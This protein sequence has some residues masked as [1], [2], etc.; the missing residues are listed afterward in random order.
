MISTNAMID[1][2][3]VVRVPAPSPLRDLTIPEMSGMTKI[4]AIGATGRMS[5]GSNIGQKA[6]INTE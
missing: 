5:Y 2:P 3:A 4:S 6:L 1:N